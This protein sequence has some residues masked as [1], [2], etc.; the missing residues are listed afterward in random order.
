MTNN[1]I[2]L[3]ARLPKADLALHTRKVKLLEA[4]WTVNCDIN[5]FAMAEVVGGDLAGL[6]KLLIGLIVPAEQEAFAEAMRSAAGLTAE[7]LTAILSGLVEAASDR[8]T[9]SPSPSRR[10]A[11][12]PKSVRKSPAR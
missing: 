6:S 12:S 4:E 1:I 7:R 10:T 2:D 11:A 9:K 3:D 5:A 8:P